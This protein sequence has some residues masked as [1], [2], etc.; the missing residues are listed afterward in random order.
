ML[1]EAVAANQVRNTVR[2]R[3]HVDNTPAAF[4]SVFDS[5]AP[6]HFIGRMDNEC[7]FCGAM[8][9]IGS[10]VGVDGSGPLFS[11]KCCLDGV[12]PNSYPL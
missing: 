3:R 7:H 8:F 12:V 10:K 6:P 4:I 2:Q 5:S 1:R 9:F 11:K